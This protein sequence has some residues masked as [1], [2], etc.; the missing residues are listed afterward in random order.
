[1]AVRRGRREGRRSDRR[2]GE[3]GL[4]VRRRRRSSSA[5]WSSTAPPRT[6]TAQVR[7][8]LAMVNRHGLVAGATGTGKTKTLQRLAEQLSEHGVPVF[9]ADIKGDL[10]GIAT[11][12]RDE[13]Q[14]RCTRATEVGQT[15]GRHVV[16][17]RV[18]RARRPG[19]RHPDP[20][21]HHLVRP[22]AAVQGARPERDAGVLPRPRLPLRRQGRS[23]AARPQGPARGR[24]LPGQR[25][26]Q[27]R[28]R[29]ARRAVEGDGR[30]HPARAH[31]ASRTRA[32]TSF[33]G[34]PEFDTTEL[35]RPAP[36]GRGLM[37][38]LELPAVQDRPALFSTFLMWLLADLFTT[39]PRS[40]T[41][42]SPSWC[43]SSTRRTC[44]SP[45]RPRTS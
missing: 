28:A 42:T 29:G 27:G 21:Q 20:G 37:S 32:P 40:V 35:L 7:I 38:V 1:M 10:S 8:P 30:R 36:D 15:V 11:A 22:A 44:C 12:G 19:R 33:F 4:R 14:G 41:S 2:A 39:C 26:G 5:P 43:S 34:E 23:A 45:T 17:G 3:A 6:P 13:R 9:L 31:R 25:R 18:L 16:P 24:R